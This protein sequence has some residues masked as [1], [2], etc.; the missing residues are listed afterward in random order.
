[1]FEPAPDFASL[2]SNHRIVSCCVARGPQKDFG[3]Y[4]AF[5][6]L[7]WM[8]LQFMLDDV[9][10]KL[11]AAPRTAEEVTGQNILEFVED[12]LTMDFGSI[13]WKMKNLMDWSWFNR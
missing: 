11:L 10:K 7:F 6:N 3:S 13:R 5:F 9:L 1:L 8:T 12:V 4:R 2:D